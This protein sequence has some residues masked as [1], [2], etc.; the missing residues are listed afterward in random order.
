[1]SLTEK[2]KP[3]L[4]L[5]EQLGIPTSIQ[6]ETN[7]INIKGNAKTQYQKDRIWDKLKEIGGDTPADANADISVENTDHYHI[8]TVQPGDSLGKIAKEILGDAGKYQT[9]YEANT[10]QLNN[11]DNIQV[12]QELKIPYIR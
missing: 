5:A 8:Y 11:P 7:R 4:D 3:V 6:E 10:D 9:I 1:M 2:Y 12:G